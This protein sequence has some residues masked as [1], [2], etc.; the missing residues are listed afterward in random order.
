LVLVLL[1]AVLFLALAS[2]MALV[3]S[4]ETTISATFRESAAA[5]AGAEAA[6][7][8]VSADL[9][10]ASDVNAVLAGGSMSSFVDGPAGFRTLPDGTQIELTELTNIERCGV[11]VC[12]DAQLSAATLDRPWG[13]NNPRWQRYASG[14]LR[15]VTPESAAPHVYVVVWVG[16]DP[17][18]HDGDPLTD[19]S[20]PGSPGHDAVLIRS[21]AYAGYSVRRRLEVVARRVDGG[22]QLGSWREIR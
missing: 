22:V 3:A 12:T 13:A 14:W 18:E 20:D 10:A 8:R 21:M 9:S 5:L 4:S 6:I 19:D 2:A 11:P 15:D 7:A 17:L 16:D 1:C